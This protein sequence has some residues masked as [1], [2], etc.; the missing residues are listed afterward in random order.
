MNVY[1]TPTGRRVQPFDDH[2]G[3]VL[4][5]NRPLHIWQ[6]EAFKVA[7]LKPIADKVAPCLVVPDTLFCHGALLKTFVEKAAGRNAT[8]LWADPL[9]KG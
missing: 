9:G 5:A 8:L 3:D 1:V 4:V 7:G 2:V 6:E